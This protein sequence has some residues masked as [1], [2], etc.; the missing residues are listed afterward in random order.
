MGMAALINALS[1][2]DNSVSGVSVLRTGTACLSRSN[3]GPNYI[4][5]EFMQDFS[6]LPAMRVERYNFGATDEP[7]LTPTVSPTQDPMRRGGQSLAQRRTASALDVASATSRPAS[8]RA[9]SITSRRTGGAIKVPAA[10]AARRRRRSRHAQEG[11][12]PGMACV[13]TPLLTSVPV[14]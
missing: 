1:T 12:A 3:E 11:G 7:L 5:V 9:T 4:R 14:P 8:A 10:T 6:S 13:Q 2:I